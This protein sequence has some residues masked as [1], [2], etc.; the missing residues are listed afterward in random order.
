[1]IFAAIALVGAVVAA[2]VSVG[3]LGGGIIVGGGNSGAHWRGSGFPGPARIVRPDMHDHLLVIFWFDGQVQGSFRAW[4]TQR[5]S[6]CIV[7]DR[8]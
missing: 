4:L 2:V 5:S 7:A 6:H 8:V 1:M 3:D